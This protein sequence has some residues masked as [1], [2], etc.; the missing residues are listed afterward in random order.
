MSGFIGHPVRVHAG[1]R[2]RE[3]DFG[4]ADGCLTGIQNSALYSAA[5]FLSPSGGGE[6]D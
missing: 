3:N 1:G 6:Q 4:A 5:E 2:I